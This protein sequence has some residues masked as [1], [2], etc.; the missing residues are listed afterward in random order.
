[1][2][3]KLS[4]RGKKKETTRFKHDVGKGKIA[5]KQS[6]SSYDRTIIQS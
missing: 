1:M 2:D 6:R 3:N 4:F 5:P